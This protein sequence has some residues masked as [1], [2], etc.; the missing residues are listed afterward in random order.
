[1]G[2]GCGVQPCANNAISSSSS[3]SP[4]QR[5][6]LSPPTEEEPEKDRFSCSPTIPIP[7]TAGAQKIKSFPDAE[8]AHP[9]VP[10]RC[11]CHRRSFPSFQ[12]AKEEEEL[13][14]HEPTLSAVVITSPIQVEGMKGTEFAII[15]KR[16]CH[17]NTFR[18]DYSGFS[19]FWK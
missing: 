6:S 12:L 7:T 18:K 2:E 1:M 8:C 4:M 15:A 10:N 3:D 14:V 13:L 11:L 19:P 17:G 5:A 16:G 9:F